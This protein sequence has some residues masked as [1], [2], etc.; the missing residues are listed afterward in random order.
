MNRDTRLIG[1]LGTGD[2]VPTRYYRPG[3]NEEGVTTP[4]GTFALARMLQPR[5]VFIA[6]TAAAADRHAARISEEF[7]SAGLTA[8]AIVTLHDGKTPAELWENFSRLKALIA[9]TEARRIVFDITHGFR[10]QPFFAGAVLSFVRAIGGTPAETEVVYAAYDARTADNRTP[11]WNLTPFAELV[12][13]TH[14]IRQL[15]DTGDARAV[16]RRAEYLGRS[17]SKQWADAGRPGQQPRLR[18]FSQA[19]ADFS[20]ALVTVRIGDLLLAKDRLPSASKRLA[21]IA[22]IIREELAVNAPPLAEALAGIEAMARPL[23]LEQDH[24]AGTEG[25]RVSAALARLYWRLGR[26]AEAGIALREGWVN[27][28]A[29]RQACRPGFDDYEERSR[30]QAERNWTGESRHHLTITRVRNDLEHGGFRKRPEPAAAIQKQLERLIAEFERAESF[31]SRPVSPATTWFVSRHPGA[32]EWAARKGL[33][34]DR[35]ITHLEIDEVKPGD[36]VI[37]TLP[38]NLAADVCARGARYLNLSL[39]LPESA[40]GRE[41]AADELERFGARLESFVVERSK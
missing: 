6:C 37:G 19:L 38:V 16:A 11:I 1:F 33:H 34:V 13:W 28:C 4:Y 17:L 29:D 10:S 41:L 25:K 14:A 12:D 30:A 8:P 27:L 24:L 18:E 39:D 2:Y 32:R 9:Q 36:T 31:A 5:E 15:L 21:D 3:L 26:Y 35:Q 22:A 23:I 20:D 7:A 40:R